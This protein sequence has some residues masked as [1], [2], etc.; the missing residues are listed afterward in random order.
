LEMIVAIL[1]VLK[2]GGAYVPLDAA[3][4]RERLAFILEDTQS[5]VLLTQSQLLRNLPEPIA[6]VVCLDTDGE[7]IARESA[8]NPSSAVAAGN[9]AY[10]IYTS[11]STGKPKGV[12]ISHYNVVRLFEATYPW[13]HFDEKDVWTLFHSYAFDFSVWEIWGA[14]LYGGRLVVV[15]YWVSRSPGVFYTLLRTE[16]VTVLNQTPSAFRQLIVAEEALG[17]AK[18]LTLRL[19]IFGGEALELNSL[20][21][22]FDRHGDRSPQLVN[23]YGITETTVHVTYRPLTIADLDKAPGSV[24]GGPIPDLQVYVLDQHLQPVPIGV[25]G[26][27]YV[28]GA[29]LARG[30]LNRPELT[31]EQ[32]IPNPFGDKSG[33]RLYKSGDL[34]RYLPNGDIEYLGRIDHQVKLRG[35]RIELG[36]IETALS[37]HPAVRE[38]VV[39]A[40]EDISDE[41]RLVAYIIP[42]QKQAPR[43]SELR[44][45]LNKKLPDYMVPSAFVTLDALPLTPNGKVDRRM[46]P[47]P[48]MVRPDLEKAFVAPRDMLELQLTTIWEQVLGL[49]SVG[50]RDNFFELGGHSLLVVRLFAQIE[51]V[52]GKNLPLAT[53]FQAPTVEQLANILRREEGAASWPS[54]VA[55]QS[56]GSNRPFFC[57]PGNLGNVFVDLGDLVR[58]LGPDQPVYGLQDGI[59]NPSQIEALAAH[60]VDEIRSVQPEGPYLLGGV[61]SGGVVAFEMARQLQ[62]EGQK[63]A[64]LALI[65]PPP[66]SVPGLQAYFDLM[67]PALRL[68]LPRFSH[69]SRVLLQHSSAE[70]GTYL[71]LKAKLVANIWAVARYIPQTYAGQVT[72]FLSNK[73]AAGSLKDHRLDWQE[74]AAGGLEVHVVPGS[75]DAI[76]RTHD[77]ILEE[78]Q[79]QVLAGQLRTCID[80]VLADECGSKA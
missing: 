61:C 13:F 3:Y 18:D 32:F 52:F 76:T 27:L 28:G 2:A 33:A 67:L 4:P 65:E 12:L 29:G 77:A 54:L 60:Y 63:V 66:P 6:R 9:L 68:A 46:L 56:G 20:K 45:F 79:V 75:H 48:E 53:L 50:V 69:H 22:W 11:G 62:A 21:P 10:V 44:S 8:E 51:R 5:P 58:H 17:T 80:S 34:A 70:R 47:V 1:G 57:I 19:V 38:T 49:Q 7:A 42:D 26:E 37:Q 43:I 24:I 30:Y 14:L 23:M 16:Q 71:R 64:L 39:L 31:A 73:S 40:R 78:S 35:F 25:P 74:L 41:K 36:E 72:L 15:P 55:I 59:Q